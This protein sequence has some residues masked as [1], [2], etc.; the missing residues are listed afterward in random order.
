MTLESGL[1]F[2]KNLKQLRR[3]GVCRLQ[4]GFMKS[5]QDRRWVKKDWPL[6]QGYYHENL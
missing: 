3:V 5:P 6:L 4:N 2:L 1:G